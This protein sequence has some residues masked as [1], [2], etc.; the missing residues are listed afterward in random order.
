M[1]AVAL[2]VP[3]PAGGGGGGGGVVVVG[4]GGGGVVVVVGSTTASPMLRVT[5]SAL[6]Y[7]VADPA[8]TPAAMPPLETVATVFGVDENVTGTPVMTVP[9][10]SRPMAVICV[11]WPAVT[12]DVPT[13]SCTM[14]TA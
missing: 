2:K 5:V 13:L 1:V 9:L 14:C 4:G 7:T 10:M 11:T 8:L 6:A 3:V 12:C